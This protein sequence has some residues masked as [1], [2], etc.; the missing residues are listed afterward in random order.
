M[1][2]AA[3]P[4]LGEPLGPPVERRDDAVAAALEVGV[5]AQDRLELAPDLPREVTAR[6]CGAGARRRGRPARPGRPRARSGVRFVQ[7][8]PVSEPA[9]DPVAADDGRRGLG[10]D[11]PA[12]VVLLGEAV[13]IERRWRL[14]QAGEQGG[15][16]HRQLGQ[17]A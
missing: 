9:Q 2:A 13:R 8:P 6:G 4:A 3:E 16:G 11:E 15:L 12:L 10:H 17:V 5:R 1:A 7:R 14:G